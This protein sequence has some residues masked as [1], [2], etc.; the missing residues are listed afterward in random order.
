MRGK[1]GK[2]DEAEP[3]YSRIQDIVVTKLGDEDLM[4]AATLNNRA[5]LY[6]SQVS[7][8]IRAKRDF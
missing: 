6:E 1:Q 5:G 8:I 3:L 4:Y 7:F 2:L